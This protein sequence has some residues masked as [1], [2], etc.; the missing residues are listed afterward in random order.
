MLSTDDRVFSTLRRRSSA[1]YG[2]PIFELCSAQMREHA[3]NWLKAQ[4]VTHGNRVC[5]SMRPAL[6]NYSVRSGFG[7][8]MPGLR[9]VAKEVHRGEH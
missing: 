8:S 4:F 2:Y 6:Y 1:Q 5:Q 3:S 7:F 9:P